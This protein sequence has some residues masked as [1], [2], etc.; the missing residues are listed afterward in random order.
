[1]SIEETN[2]KRFEQDIEAFMLS[3]AGGYTKNTSAYDPKLGLFTDTLT[4]FVKETQP[5]A[6]KRFALQNNG[7]L[8]RK[9]A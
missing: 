9:F 1:M 7:N 8:E 4:D 6:W 5:K 2:E 3:P